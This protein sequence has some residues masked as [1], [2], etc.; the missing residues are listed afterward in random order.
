MSKE[1]TT[2]D[3]IATVLFKG[4]EE[5]ANF[6][7]NRELAQKDRWMLCVSKL[8]EDPMTADKEI[9]SFLI[10]GCGGNCEPVSTATAYRDLASIRRLV[11]N[12]QLAA[13]NWYRYMVIE[14]AKEGIR[15]ARE[16]KDPKGIAANADKI[17]KYTRSDKEDDEIDRTG[18][19]PP[20]FEPSD[21]V[22][23]MGDDFK[24]IPNLEEERKSFRALFKQ[25]HD[26]VDIEPITDDDGTDD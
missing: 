17:G 14:A 21:D 1:F 13:K 8:L 24:P 9:V 15:I 22:T 7:S 18:W 12:V 23:L 10:G 6:L 19:E 20:C 25:D 3:K 4:H 2:Y 26:I 16:A 11:G 5:A